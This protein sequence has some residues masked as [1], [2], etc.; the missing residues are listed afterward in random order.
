[1][2]GGGVY[3][4]DRQLIHEITNSGDVSNG[5]HSAHLVEVDLADRYT[6]DMAFCLGNDIIHRKDL[7]A[8]L[9]GDPGMLHDMGD[10]GHAAVVVMVVMI[11]VVIFFVS[12]NQNTDVAAGNAAF[13]A[14]FNAERHSGNPKT[15]QFGKGLFPVFCQFQQ[16]GGEH[17]AGSAHAA[18]DIEC[19]HRLT[20]MWLIMLAR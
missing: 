20:S 5:I 9:G 4:V 7:L 10:V 17:I 3:F 1:M 6:V 8:H 13:Y 11:V 16:C 15:V 19:F 14:F 12:V 2:D 18:V